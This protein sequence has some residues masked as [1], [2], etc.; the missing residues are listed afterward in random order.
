[1]IDLN[2][3]LQWLNALIVIATIVAFTQ[4][5][6]N[7]YM[8]GTTVVLAVLLGVQTHLALLVE[9]RR[10]D[11]FVFM[12]AFILILYFS[13]R[14]LTLLLLP[15][16]VVFDRFAYAPSD[17]NV[18]LLF[19]LLANM[20]F[21][22]GLFVV[23][24]RGRL[25]IDV[26]AWR[27]AA[28]LRTWL[29]VAAAI[30]LLYSRGVLWNPNDSPRL[31]QVFF[32]FASQSVVT[33]MALAYYL[34]FRRKMSWQLGAAFLA[35]LI[36]EM[37][38]HTLAGSRSAFVYG[39]QNALIVLLAVRGSVALPRRA[40]VAA[41]VGLPLAIALLV[42]AFIVST[43]VAT[44][45]ASGVPMTAAGALEASQ[46]AGARLDRQYALEA[47][48]PLIFGRAGF[49]D[50]SAEIIAHRRQYEPVVNPSAYVRSV[51]DNLLTPGFD[52]FDQPKIANALKFVY[53]DRGAP[54]KRASTEE[55]QSDQLG[56]Y[57]ELFVLFGY[58]SLPLFFVGGFLIKRAYF[59]MRAANP[60]VLAMKRIVTL[61]IFA[62][63]VNSYGFDW[64]LADI[65]PLVAGIYLLQL[66]FAA[67]PAPAG[68]AT[69][70]FQPETA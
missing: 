5:G 28:P 58:A 69:A 25:P 45:R 65:V 24:S 40:V 53:A 4:V 60:F 33:L 12:L 32:A 14:L 61:V 3:I 31:L 39:L 38:I 50:F 47:G 23:R 7:E 21:Y 52:L 49:F 30:G 35:L 15:F 59:G 20:F 55:Y 16:S 19:I 27:P 18:A 26:G 51:V 17:S 10:R 46:A 42:V 68:Q 56:V 41:I 8:D 13:L 29:F 22:A 66:F 36:L 2:R 34:V 6:G 44:Y 48:L 64:T 62:E 43:T 57:G 67:S 1:M 63:I 70:V 37:I 11:P 54:S 9:R